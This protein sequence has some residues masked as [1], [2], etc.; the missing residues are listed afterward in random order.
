MDSLTPF[1]VVAWLFLLIG[2]GSVGAQIAVCFVGMGQVA[3]RNRGL[4]YSPRHNLD[5]SL[6]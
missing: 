4:P 5:T 6:S 3:V 2:G 1:Y